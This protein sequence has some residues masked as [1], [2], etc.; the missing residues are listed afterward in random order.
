MLNKKLGESVVIMVI[1]NGCGK[2]GFFYLV[3][4]I[5]Y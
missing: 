4:R 3:W 1:E 5:I 2:I